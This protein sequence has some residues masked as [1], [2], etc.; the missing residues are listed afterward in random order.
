[1]VY[2]RVQ[3]LADKAGI[4]IYALEHDAGLKNGTIGKWRTSIP[5]VKNLRAVADVLGVTLNDITD[6]LSFK[7]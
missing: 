4:P 1:M 7:D 2:D 5:T 6:G 3:E